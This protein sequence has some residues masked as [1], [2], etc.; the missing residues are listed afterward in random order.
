[1]TKVCNKCSAEKELDQFYKDKNHSLDYYSICKICKDT[2]TVNW[3][4]NN[5]D[6]YV[7]QRHEAKKLTY[8]RDR[9]YRYNITPEQFEFMVFLQQGKCAICGIKPN[10]KRPLVIDHL[11]NKVRALLCYRCNR[12][13]SVVDNDELLQ[14]SID[15]KKKHRTFKAA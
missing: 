10:T 5:N 6:Y 12:N 7:N 9:L 15:Y 2:S 1:M 4:Q 11:T 3:R 13:M 8:N 14:K